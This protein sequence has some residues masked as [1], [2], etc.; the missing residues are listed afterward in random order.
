MSKVTSKLQVTIPKD[1]AEAYGIRPGSD[2][3]WMP[4][5]DSIRVE[6]EI[7]RSRSELPVEKRLEIFDRMMK[8]VDRLPPI[9]P[10]PPGKGRGWTREELYS[11]RLDRYGRPR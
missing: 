8:R 2:I 3:R 1:I 9:A 4:A 5:G 6:P 10:A 11:D 7:I